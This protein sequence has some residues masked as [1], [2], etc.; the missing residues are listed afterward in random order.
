VKTVKGLTASEWEVAEEYVEVFIP[1]KVMSSSMFSTISMVIPELN[2]LKH[3]LQN[4]TSLPTLKEDLL[5]SINRRWPEYEAN[6]LYAVSTTVDP[7]YKDCGFSDRFDRTLNSMLGKV[8]SER[9]DYWDLMLLLLYAMAAY[10]ISIYYI[11]G[12][13]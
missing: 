8:I 3:T 1:F 9:Q 7:R 13:P 5:A 4:D 12:C 10:R 11:W 2:K 6:Q